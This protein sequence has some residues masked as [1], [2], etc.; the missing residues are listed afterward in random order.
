M[1]VGAVS[2]LL[3]GLGVEREETLRLLEKDH[4]AAD[5]PQLHSPRGHR[6]RTC[7]TAG[8]DDVEVLCK[9]V[10]KGVHE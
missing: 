9:L 6:G 10:E 8:G 4:R 5:E 2:M 3:Y 1:D 7:P